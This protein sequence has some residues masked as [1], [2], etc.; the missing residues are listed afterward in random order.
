MKISLGWTKEY[1][2]AWVRD[3][4]T[5]Y[6]NMSFSFLYFLISLLI[7]IVGMNDRT[8][9]FFWKKTANGPYLLLSRALII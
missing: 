8:L 3:P 4:N 6:N 9:E 1:L 7:F 5:V 2:L